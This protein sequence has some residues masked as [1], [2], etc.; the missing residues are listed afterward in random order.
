MADQQPPVNFLDNPRAPEIYISA[1]TGFFNE[2]G[3]IHITFESNRIDHS[4]TPGP[5]NR[6]VVCR[7][8]MNAIAAQGLAVGLFDFLKQYGLAPEMAP[9]EAVQKH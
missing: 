7:L 5:C 8:A 6:V 2:N 4:T 1:A 3:V 9:P